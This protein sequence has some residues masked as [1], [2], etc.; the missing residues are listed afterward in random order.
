MSHAYCRFCIWCCDQLN[1]YPVSKTSH[2]INIWSIYLLTL[3]LLSH[4]IDL[5]TIWSSPSSSSPA[6]QAGTAACCS[7]S[8][9]QV[10]ILSSSW[11]VRLCRE[12]ATYCPVAPSHAGWLWVGSFFTWTNREEKAR[13]WR[14]P[15]WNP[16]FCCVWV[17]GW[18]AGD[19]WDGCQHVAQ[20]SSADPWNQLCLK[21]NNLL[22]LAHNYFGI[23][24]GWRL[25]SLDSQSGISFNPT[26][27]SQG[28]NVVVMASCKT[29]PVEICW[30]LLH[31]NVF[32]LFF[33]LLA[34][35][36]PLNTIVA[37]CRSLHEMFP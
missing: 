23:S 15:Y 11:P 19:Q 28:S 27:V 13:Q 12:L 14:A 37:E 1:M 8:Q 18:W 20:V 4:P 5:S 36:F 21:G 10:E 22:W 25:L 9:K 30:G 2:W 35:I 34:A 32:V 29:A 7:F 26:L 6:Q 33:V 3:V 17:A 24:D 16:S 31:R